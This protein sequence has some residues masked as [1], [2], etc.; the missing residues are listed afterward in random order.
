MRRVMPR[1]T[2]LIPPQAER[3]FKGI[4]YD[5]YHWQQ[6]RFDGSMATFEMLKRPDT[7]KVIAV[8]GEK[9]VAILDKQPSYEPEFTLPGGRNDVEAEDE[10]ACA[11]REVRE[12]IGMTFKTWK[13]LTARQ[14]HP[15]IEQMIYVFLAT[16]L[17]HEH[18]PQQDPGGEEIE[19]RE[20]SF[21]EAK[22]IQ[23]TRESKYWPVDIFARVNSLQELLDLP[24]YR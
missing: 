10:L 22:A 9:I 5:V 18:A 2:H 24:E 21:A 19:I 3:V 11:K 7:V 16:D 14:F 6:K 15:K 20:I 1:N 13:L 17:E 8:K 12:E 23:D 4:I